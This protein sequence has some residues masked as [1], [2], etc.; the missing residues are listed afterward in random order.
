MPPSQG[1]VFSISDE[2]ELGK[3]LEQGA[4]EEIGGMERQRE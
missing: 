3:Q 1:D 4:Q 2:G